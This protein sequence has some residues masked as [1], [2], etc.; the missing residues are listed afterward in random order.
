MDPKV[1]KAIDWAVTAVLGL[2]VIALIF[3]I[4]VG[5]REINGISE[6]TDTNCTVT[7]TIYQHMEW[8][9]RVEYELGP[10]QILELKALVLESTFTRG[11]RR[12]VVPVDD[13]DR[14]DIVVVFDQGESVRI[15]SLGNQYIDIG[16]DA[17]FLKIHNRNWKTALN[18]LVAAN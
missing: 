12:G 10:E 13:L 14:Y 7:I 9:D 6:M 4:R 15:T 2:A 8:D 18:D 3:S 1:I 17:G 16:D 5:G 11:L